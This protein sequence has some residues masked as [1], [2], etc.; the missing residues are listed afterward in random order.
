MKKIL[1]VAVAFLVIGVAC[2]DKKKSEEK[3]PA[4]Q[5][6]EQPVPAEPDTIAQQIEEPE[7][8]PEPVEPDKYFLIAGSFSKQT[9]AETFKNKL[10][11]EGFQAEVITRSWGPNSEFYK[12]AYMGFRDKNEAI[13][14][15]KQERNQ[16]G[17]EDVWVLVKK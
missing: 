17:K 2:K 11:Q 16:S 7:P 3:E 13:S 1:L 9:N 6:V 5:E 8:E 14:K 12:V 15:M 10:G 4:K